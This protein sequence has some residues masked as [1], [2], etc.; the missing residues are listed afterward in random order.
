MLS[1]Q[2]ALGEAFGR[3]KICIIPQIDVISDGCCALAFGILGKSLYLFSVSTPNFPGS[4]NDW[5]HAYKALSS[6]S[7]AYN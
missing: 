4:L 3:A 5:D 1:L 7:T 2:R 6:V